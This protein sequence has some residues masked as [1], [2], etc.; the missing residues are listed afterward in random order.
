[1][2]L[3]HPV[4]RAAVTCPV[5]HEPKD[6]GLVM[7]WPCHRAN[8]RNAF[9]AFVRDQ[10]EYFEAGGDQRAAQLLAAVERALRL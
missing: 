10:V 9:H 1:M 6:K 4:C 5:C 2:M 8:K 7:C 3:D